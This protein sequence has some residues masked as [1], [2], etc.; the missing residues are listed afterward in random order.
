MSVTSSLLTPNM[1]SSL[2]FKMSVST[3]YAFLFS[4]LMEIQKYLMLVAILVGADFCTGIYAAWKRK[5]KIVAAGFRRTIEKVVWYSLA[6]ILSHGMDYVFN[7]DQLVYAV[8]IFICLT[9]FKGNL[10]NISE[11]TGIG[12]VSAVRDLI[13]KRLKPTDP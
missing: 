6:I 11:I 4:E 9:E 12:I 10:E 3:L 8:A 1:K 5:E 7:F 13:T 2:L